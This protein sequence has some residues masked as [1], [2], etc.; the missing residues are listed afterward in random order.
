M[1]G[2]LVGRRRRQLS[3]HCIWIQSRHQFYGHTPRSDYV[4]YGHQSEPHGKRQQLHR[5]GISPRRADVRFER[6]E[7]V[8]DT[9]KADTRALSDDQLD[10]VSGGCIIPS[11]IQ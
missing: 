9:Q 1:R 8:M 2:Q 6:Q 4:H 11:G 10:A 7:T 5:S 3:F